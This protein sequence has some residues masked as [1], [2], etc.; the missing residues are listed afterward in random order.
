[1]TAVGLVSFVIGLFAPLPLLGGV[2]VGGALLVAA[3]GIGY[4]YIAW[5]ADKEKNR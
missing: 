2:L 4:S 5:R 1:M 3:I